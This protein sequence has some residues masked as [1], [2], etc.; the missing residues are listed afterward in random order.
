[1]Q[2]LAQALADVKVPVKSAPSVRE[3]TQLAR[4]LATSPRVILLDIGAGSAQTLEDIRALRDSSATKTVQPALYALAANAQAVDT[5]GIRG[6]DGVAGYFTRPVD[7]KLLAS[8][9]SAVMTDVEVESAYRRSIE[10]ADRPSTV[11]AAVAPKPF[12]TPRPV[13]VPVRSTPAASGSGTVVQ[14][15]A[16]LDPGVVSPEGDSSRSRR[17]IIVVAVVVAAA[18][19]ALAIGLG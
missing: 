7:P 15:S 18:G 12:P 13:G 11:R 9:F 8:T 3:A 2:A 1:M 5:A 17:I 16:S 14:R 4:R 10:V 6:A 19:V